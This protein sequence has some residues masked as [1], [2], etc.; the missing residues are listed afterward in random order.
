[1]NEIKFPC[2]HLRSA[3][4]YPAQHPACARESALIPALRRELT[5]LAPTPTCSVSSLQAS[6]FL[7]T[8]RAKRRAHQPARQLRP[9]APGS[10]PVLGYP[11]WPRGGVAHAF[12]P[13][14]GACPI[15][16]LAAPCR[17]G[18]KADGCAAAAAV[19]AL[20]CR[21]C[22]PSAVLWQLGPTPPSSLPAGARKSA[23]TTGQAC[24]MPAMPSCLRFWA[25]PRATK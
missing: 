18:S 22:F 14:R 25:A 7:I 12:L 1:M 23:K 9:L 8:T 4:A 15:Q 13:R 16:W 17:R 2:G 20:N 24:P 3:A 11:S 21:S 19:S 10:E 6:T 5:P